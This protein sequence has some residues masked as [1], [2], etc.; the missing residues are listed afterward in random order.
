MVYVTQLI[1]VRETNATL[2]AEFDTALSTLVQRHSGMFLFRLRPDPLNLIAS[3]IGIPYEVQLLRFETED[4]FDNFMRDEERK[5]LLLAKEHAI[6]SV[7]L[8]K[9]QLVASA[10]KKSTIL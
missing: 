9:G 6:R 4:G 8:I 3:T 10:T 2:F 5:H 1:H 7:I